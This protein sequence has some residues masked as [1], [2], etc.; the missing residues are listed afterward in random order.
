MILFFELKKHFF[1]LVTAAGFALAAT[2]GYAQ[3]TIESINVSGQQGGATV[4]KINL[5]SA[6][7]AVPAS[8]AV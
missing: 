6:P 1:G 5:K 8:F 4:V 7:A 2:A 3:N